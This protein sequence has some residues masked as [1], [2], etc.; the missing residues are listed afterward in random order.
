MGDKKE[1]MGKRLGK[2]NVVI[3]HIDMDGNGIWGGSVGV[4]KEGR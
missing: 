1:N 3:R 4:E 2:K